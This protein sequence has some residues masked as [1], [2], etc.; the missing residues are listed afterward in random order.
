MRSLPNDPTMAGR[1][2]ALVPRTCTALQISE[3]LVMDEDM[4]RNRLSSASTSFRTFP[5]VALVGY[6][7][8]RP[9]RSQD[10]TGQGRHKAGHVPRG[11]LRLF[12]CTAL[13]AG[14]MW[15]A[16]RSTGAAVLRLFACSVWCNPR[17]G[18]YANFGLVLRHIGAA[19]VRGYLTN[20]VR[21]WLC[22][23][24]FARQSMSLLQ[25]CF[26][27]AQDEFLLIRHLY[28]LRE[29]SLAYSDASDSAGVCSLVKD[30]ED[31]MGLTSLQV[32]DSWIQARA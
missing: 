2:L 14:H 20:P 24:S 3:A 15:E 6:E 1:L 25:T 32:S 9:S 13:L 11:L 19:C 18:A 31:I 16:P 27:L 7:L 17:S 4:V 12:S 28:G 30:A 22:T 8:F 26:A 5:Y 23:R 29:L 10:E 21:S